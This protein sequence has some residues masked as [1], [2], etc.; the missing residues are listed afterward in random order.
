MQYTEIIENGVK[1]IKTPETFYNPAQKINRD[2]TILCINEYIKS[3]PRPQI[4]EAMS[5]TGLRGIRFAKEL[6]ECDIFLN[7]SSLESV[8]IIKHNLLNNDINKTD[9]D[10]NFRYNQKEIFVTNSDCNVILCKN[11]NKFDVIDIDP[12]GSPTPFI[13]NAL[14][15]I[16]HNGLLCLTSTD[17]GVLCSNRKK[18]LV[19]YN[20]LI[21]PG[22]PAHHDHALR[23]LLGYVESQAG[24][25]G[26][27]IEPII[28]I[29]IDFYIRVFL[30]IKRKKVTS[31]NISYYFYCSCHNMWKVDVGDITCRNCGSAKYKLCGPYYDGKMNDTSFIENI[32][33][34]TSNERITGFLNLLK[35]E[36]DDFMLYSIPDMSKYIKTNCIPLSAIL[37]A[38][39]N[40][41]YEVSLSHCEINAIKTTANIKT[42]YSIMREYVKNK[43]GLIFNVNERTS[44]IL[45]RKYFRG[46]MFSK[47]GPLS[48]PKSTKK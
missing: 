36:V 14:Y 38:L 34:K 40:Q 27:T 41:N 23:I 43:D 32:M 2:L 35:Y 46:K 8:N 17:T 4:F 31:L 15:S 37:S 21:A 11:V 13:N 16:K 6:K 44:E 22:N 30:R 9:N 47:K 10:N 48:I 1:I 25:Y 18:C 7:D 24:K 19:K 39:L 3:T 42:L 33:K 20:T 29:S 45:N 28:S 26:K 5:A 12:F